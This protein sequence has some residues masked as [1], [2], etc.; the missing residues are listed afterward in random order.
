MIDTHQP[1]TMAEVEAMLDCTGNTVVERIQ[2]GELAA[3]KIG[4]SW[5]FPRDAFHESLASLAR[6]EAAKRREQHQAKGQA[7]RAITTA[8]QP[9][10]RVPPPLSAHP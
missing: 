8:S 2:A 3:I 1:Y 9:R 10:R 6:E 4:R 7:A 5:I